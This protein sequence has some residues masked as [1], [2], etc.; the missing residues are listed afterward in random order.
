M[1]LV[2]GFGILARARAKARS[3]RNVYSDLAG[4]EG[5]SEPLYG[6]LPG[7]ATTA[8][9]ATATSKATQKRKPGGVNTTQ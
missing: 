6:R 2:V 5:K 1:A 7:T 4:D 3:A 8:T 9:A